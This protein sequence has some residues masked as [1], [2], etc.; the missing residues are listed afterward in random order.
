MA[1]DWKSL[2]KI[3][4]PAIAT[5]FGSPLAGLGVR[6]LSEAL[7]GRDDGSEA[8]IEQ[9]MLSA[10]PDK[11][12]ELKKADQQFAAQMKAMDIDLDKAFIADTSDARHVFGAN[13]NV[14][15]LGVSIL[16]TFAGIMGA[17]LWGSFEIMTG[18]ITIQDVA[19]VATVSGMIGTVVGYVAAN[20]QQVVSYFFGSSRGSAEK[21][22]AMADSIHKFSQKM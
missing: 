8:D 4:A 16:M 6:A 10:T 9:A 19:I 12:L 21:T 14:F 13:D 11:L 15:W 22:T 3:V 2:V 1:A 7:L 5:A 17:V 20:A 18:G